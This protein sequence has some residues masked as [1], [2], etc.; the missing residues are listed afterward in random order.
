MKPRCC[1]QQQKLIHQ[2]VVHAGDH[3]SA[4]HQ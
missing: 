4:L 3:Q 1:D 2:H